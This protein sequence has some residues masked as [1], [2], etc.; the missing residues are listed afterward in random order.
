MEKDTTAEI[1]SLGMCLI[2]ASEP[3]TA[4]PTVT[5]V[6]KKHLSNRVSV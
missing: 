3:N 2:K 6:A 1:D 5:Q 4:H